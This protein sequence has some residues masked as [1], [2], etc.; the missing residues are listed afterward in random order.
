MQGGLHQKDLQMG[1]CCIFVMVVTV[2]LWNFRPGTLKGPSCSRIPCV[3]KWSHHV[4]ICALGRKD[5]NV[6]QF[7]VSW[8]IH[9]MISFYYILQVTSGS[10]IANRSCQWSSMSKEGFP[11]GL[12][13]G[14]MGSLSGEGRSRSPSLLPTS[15]NWGTRRQEKCWVLFNNR[16]DWRERKRPYNINQTS[17]KLKMKRQTKLQQN[18]LI[19]AQNTVSVSVG[20]VCVCIYVCGYINMCVDLQ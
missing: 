19:G 16:M 8:L 15:C 5:E 17:P 14:S 13:G 11:V 3:V 12:K 9:L 10:M 1:I 4:D 18:N 6:S 2:L 20:Q 7:I